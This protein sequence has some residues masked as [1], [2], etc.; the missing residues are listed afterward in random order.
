MSLNPRIQKIELGIEEM[1][2]YTIYPLSLAKEFQVSD[3]ISEAVVKIAE[4]TEEGGDD[5]N[6]ATVIRVAIDII[7]DNL[8]A[9]LEMVT[10]KDNRPKLDEIDNVQFSEIAEL[11]FEINFTGAIKNFQGLVRNIKGMFQSTGPSPSLSETPVT[12]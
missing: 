4:I 1:Q 12:E 9:V 11:I 2:F 7:K 5:G 10:K 8:E 6:E 3:I